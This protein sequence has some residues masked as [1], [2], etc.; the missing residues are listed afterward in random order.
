V[1]L[2]AGLAGPKNSVTNGCGSR[3][4][5]EES[6]ALGG[7]SGFWLTAGGREAVFGAPVLPA[8]A[9]L[10]VSAAAGR[11]TGLMT[12]DTHNRPK[13][14]AARRITRN[15]VRRKRDEMPAR[16]AS[17][18]PYSGGVKVGWCGAIQKNSTRRY[19]QEMRLSCGKLTGIAATLDAG[20]LESPHLQLCRLSGVAKL[21]GGGV[22]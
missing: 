19:G 1:G 22:G 14:S 11:A 2:I 7:G 20:A 18:L 4:E 6:V 17:L 8:S 9:R 21:A 15:I 13:M 5:K 12:A 3:G 16:S 10:L